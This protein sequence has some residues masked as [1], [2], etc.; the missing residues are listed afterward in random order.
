MIIKGAHQDTYIK[1]QVDEKLA[2]RLRRKKFLKLNLY[3]M[4]I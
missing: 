4:R 3:L 1:K 2:K